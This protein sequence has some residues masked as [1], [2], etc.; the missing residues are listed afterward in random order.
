ML[1]SVLVKVAGWLG[2]GVFDIL[3]GKVADYC[4]KRRATI[5][6]DFKPV[7]RPIPRSRWRRSMHRSRRASPAGADHGSRSR[8]VGDVLDPA[9]DRHPCVL[10]FGAISAGSTFA[11]G[12]GIAKLPAPYDG[13][14]QAIILSFFIARPF[15][16]VRADVY[17]NAEVVCGERAWRCDYGFVR[18][19]VRW[20][21]KSMN[22]REAVA[23]RYSC[24]AF[25]SKLYPREYCPARS[26]S[27]RRARHRPAICSRGGSM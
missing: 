21:P 8:L 2:G 16:K 17:G 1:T 9:A 6:H 3:I 23:S 27:L 20:R 11:F 15:E 4:A 12:W 18:H 24:R 14:E 22:V 26:S 19:C 25:L 10:H 13:Y 5:W 7:C